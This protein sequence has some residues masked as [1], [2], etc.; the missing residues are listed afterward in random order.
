MYLEGVG[1]KSGPCT[2]T[3]NDLLCFPYKN[4]TLQ[5]ALKW[6]VAKELTHITVAI[7]PDHAAWMQLN[8]YSLYPD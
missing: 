5:K 1:K 4:G 2:A 7:P 6:T 3:F 8:L